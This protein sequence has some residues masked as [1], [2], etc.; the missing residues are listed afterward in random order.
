MIHKDTPYDIREEFA[1][2]KQ[3]TLEVY[4]KASHPLVTA[5]LQREV[6]ADL[7]AM[8]AHLMDELMKKRQSFFQVC[9]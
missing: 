8:T 5:V 7:D 9:H 4:D 6:A 3:R 1:M 2:L